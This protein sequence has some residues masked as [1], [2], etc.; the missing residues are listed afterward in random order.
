MEITILAFLA[1]TPELDE[2]AVRE[3]LSGNPCRCTGC[4]HIVDGVLLAVRW[5]AGMR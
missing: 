1:E 2:A 3:A 5:M 4:Q